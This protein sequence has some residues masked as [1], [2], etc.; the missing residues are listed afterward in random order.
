[1]LFVEDDLDYMVVTIIVTDD[2]NVRRRNGLFRISALIVID[3][4]QM[5]HML[6]A[7][8]ITL[9]YLDLRQNLS[10]GT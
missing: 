7:N 9:L 3:D 10:A 4:R 8:S 2:D 5:D 1:M 6:L